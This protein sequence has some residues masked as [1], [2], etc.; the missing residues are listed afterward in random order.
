MRNDIDK[1]GGAYMNTIDILRNKLHDSIERGN[2]EEIQAISQALDVEIVKLM[3]K[4][5]LER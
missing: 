1:E 3:K 2:D 5:L 4:R